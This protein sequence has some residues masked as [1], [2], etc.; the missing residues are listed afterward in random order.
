MNNQTIH[1][2]IVGGSANNQWASKAH[3]PALQLLPEYNITAV[4]TTRIESAKESAQHFGVPYAFADS[5]RLA[6][7]PDV[8]LV[9]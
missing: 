6:N 3:I 8:D 1:V 2:G 7:H 4:G 5:N 9:I